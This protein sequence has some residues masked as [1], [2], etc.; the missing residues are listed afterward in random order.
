VQKHVD[1]GSQESRLTL[2]D[3]GRFTVAAGRLMERDGAERFKQ[4]GLT[5]SDMPLLARL[6]RL[7]PMTPG[8]F[9]E[10]SVLLTAVPVASH[11]LNR[12]ELAGL[13]SR[14]P[15]DT[16]GR[17]KVVEATAAGR[18]V[19]VLV[20]KEIQELQAVFSPDQRQAKRRSTHD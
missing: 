7:G 14:R 9:L 13:V 3:A 2:D 1:P 5:L 20:H 12:L 6:V 11:S 18:Q 19:L 17:M 8:E 4:Y 10:S 16:D 15:H